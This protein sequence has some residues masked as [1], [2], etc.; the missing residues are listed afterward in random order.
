MMPQLSIVIPALNERDNLVRL[1]PAVG[2]IAESIGITVEVLVVDGPSRD[3]TAKAAESL[4]ARVI[5]QKERGYGGALLAG[6][7]QASSPWLLTMD[8]DLSHPPT[9]IR[10]L[11]ER[12]E[13]AELTIASRYVAGGKASMSRFRYVLSLI[14]NTV[15]RAVLRVPVRDLSS[16]F[17]LY[18]ASALHDLHLTSRDFDILEEILV[19]GCNRGWRVAEVPFHYMP[20]GSGSSHAKLI[21]FGWA[22]VR[23]LVRMVRLR[24]SAR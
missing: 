3:G 15:Y 22:Y 4:G 8:A 6:F 9:F 20:R 11:W 21:Q 17:R 18:R 12:R 13:E 5:R 14:L 2:D 23:T 1:I 16:G 24:S 10:D 7:A 19:L